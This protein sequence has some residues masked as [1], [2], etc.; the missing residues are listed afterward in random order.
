MDPAFQQTA[1]VL[2]GPAAEAQLEALGLSLEIVGQTVLAAEMDGRLTS[3]YQPPTAPGF[4]RWATACGQLAERL[5]PRGWERV[6]V[7]GLPRV[8]N[9]SNG[10]AVAVIGGDE[11]TGV[12]GATPHSR[13]SRGPASTTLVSA[14][15]M[16]LEFVSPMPDEGDPLED[17]ERTWWLLIFSD[18]SSV[19]AELS[20]AVGLDEKKKLAAWKTRILI[21]LPQA[22]FPWEKERRDDDDSDLEIDVN[23]IPR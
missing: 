19:R 14:N 21:D 23:V 8:V 3:A 2:E 6:L 1:E 17:W 11:G 7:K 22:G 4:R 5:V 9:H 13:T 10:T 12:R 18:G 16:S 20:L 15:Q